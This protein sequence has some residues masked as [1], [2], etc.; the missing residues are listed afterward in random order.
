[1]GD[2]AGIGPEIAAKAA[3]HPQVLKICRPMIIGDQKQ[4]LKRF[5][6]GQIS[7]EAGRASIEYVEKAIQLALAKKVDA[8]VT[9]PISKEAINLAGIKFPGHTE[10][11]AAR[12][13]TKNYA[14]MF[15]SKKMWV[16]LVT[17]H[18][19]LSKVPRAITK[20]RVLE[21][22]KLA[23]QARPGRIAVAGL[24]PHAGE[25][26]LF[27]RE[28]IDEIAP[29]IAAARKLGIKV[30]GPI[31]PD[32]IFNRA[33]AGAYGMVVAMYH[34]QGLIPLKLLAFGSA[35]N[36]TVGLPIIRTSV[37]HGTAFDIAGQNHADPGSMIEAI[38]AAVHFANARHS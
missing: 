10:L 3:A 31:S 20:K 7:K 33:A 27:G 16:I 8:I 36:V 38:K 24:N 5:K 13:H 28:E 9:G 2:P 12:T 1:M 11:L 37:D 17:T 29:A 6:I 4:D 30:E 15:I 34:D 18:L 26:G 32:I 22:I 25:S 19:P 23:H 35:V 21:V 14:M